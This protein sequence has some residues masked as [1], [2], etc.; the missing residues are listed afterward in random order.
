MQKLNLTLLATAVVSE[1]AASRTGNNASVAAGLSQKDVSRLSALAGHATQRGMR[2]A[3]SQLT[4]KFTLLSACRVSPSQVYRV[5]NGKYRSLAG[6]FMVGVSL[7]YF[8]ALCGKQG[9]EVRVATERDG[10]FADVAFEVTIVG[11]P[12]CSRALRQAATAAEAKLQSL[13]GKLEK[14]SARYDA[15]VSKLQKFDEEYVDALRYFAATDATVKHTTLARYEQL[16]AQ[17]AQLSRRIADLCEQLDAA[18]EVASDL[19]GKVE[20][21]RPTFLAGY[22]AH[23]MVKTVRY[24]VA[25]Y[26]AETTVYVTEEVL[27]FLI[28]AANG[29]KRKYA[30]SSVAQFLP[31]EAKNEAVQVLAKAYG[32]SYDVCSDIVV[33]RYMPDTITNE[34]GE[35]SMALP[36]YFVSAATM[37][38]LP[39]DVVGNTYYLKG[40]EVG[41][42]VSPSIVK[43]DLYDMYKVLWAY[44][45]TWA[46]KNMP[47]AVSLVSRLEECSL[48]TLNDLLSL[49]YAKYRAELI[50]R[51]EKAA[52]LLTNMAKASV[53]A[54]DAVHG[55]EVAGLNMDETM[56]KARIQSFVKQHGSNKQLKNYVGV[57][58][59]VFMSAERAAEL[60][61]M[62]ANLA[63]VEAKLDVLAQAKVAAWDKYANVVLKDE[64]GEVKPF[65]RYRSAELR[66][67]VRKADKQMRRNMA[68][69]KDDAQAKLAK[70]LALAGATEAMITYA[71]SAGKA[72]A[73]VMMAD[74]KK[75]STLT[76]EKI[77]ARVEKLIAKAKARKA[78]YEAAVKREESVL[79]AVAKSV[80]QAVKAE[81]RTSTVKAEE[82]GVSLAILSE[83]RSNLERAEAAAKALEGKKLY[84]E[85]VLCKGFAPVRTKTGRISKAGMKE[86]VPSKPV[87]YIDA[88]A[89]LFAKE[90]EGSK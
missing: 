18:E 64:K 33:G 8:E 15:V 26:V 78:N 42:L 73:K 56:L 45:Y 5:T 71:L 53:A 49:H 67:L 3:L 38:S 10:R 81:N 44:L 24:G 83:L 21:S 19:L 79:A 16:Y 77:S 40:E 90:E 7:P 63:E 41:S 32:V 76:V 87:T 37:S 25:S 84:A 20:A 43:V 66:K 14:V 2:G 22:M 80:K 75:M 58:D 13:E 70:S 47:T 62:E 68:G 57:A 52:A 50:G 39:F 61:A 88:T 82:V 74:R 46:A 23:S 59:G 9:Y 4:E 72:K 36:G 29:G 31:Y 86:F 28:A 35:Q 1:F 85:T 11:A 30:S 17:A 69:A 54:F 65:A 48:A 34:E 6:T 55:A 60:D 12:H 27:L 51:A 89:F